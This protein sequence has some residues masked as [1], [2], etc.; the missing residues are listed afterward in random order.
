MGKF[1]YNFPTM[2]EFTMLFMETIK[3]VYK[4]DI[5]GKNTYF[6]GY[7]FNDLNHHLINGKDQLQ[8]PKWTC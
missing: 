1:N 6:S 5:I 2:I 3:T 8:F 7:G 4:W